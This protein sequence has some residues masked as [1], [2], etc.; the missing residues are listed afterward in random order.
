MMTK[1]Y[2]QIIR[3]LTDYLTYIMFNKPTVYNLYYLPS[4]TNNDIFKLD[5]LLLGLIDHY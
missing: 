5:F 3:V 2:L 4:K 1:I